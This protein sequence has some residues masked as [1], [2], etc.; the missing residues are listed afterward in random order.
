MAICAVIGFFVL[1]LFF[2]DYTPMLAIF[3]ASQ[4]IP[5]C[6]AVIHTFTYSFFKLGFSVIMSS[7]YIFRFVYLTKL[8]KKLPKTSITK[9]IQSAASYIIEEHNLLCAYI[10]NSN[11]LWSGLLAI[12]IWLNIPINIFWLNQLFRF[13]MDYKE[14]FLISLATLS[15]FIGTYLVMFN[16][17]LIHK[18]A[19]KPKL[20]LFHTQ[21]SGKCFPI[22]FKLK[23]MSYIEKLMSHRRIGVTI[24][25][26]S[27]VTIRGVVKVCV[28]ISILL[29]KFP[30]ISLLSCTWDTTWWYMI[31]F[32]AIEQLVVWW[33]HIAE[34]PGSLVCQ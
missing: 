27:V 21:M 33:W 2:S 18:W 31:S 12:F 5:I 15:Q 34:N 9:A 7:V 11:E 32:T 8:S 16:I 13:E 4:Y 25:T 20:A 24:G 3:Y 28:K 6:F 17:A 23:L 29:A 22:R 1:Y 19:H 14:W 26:S 10:Q 30:C